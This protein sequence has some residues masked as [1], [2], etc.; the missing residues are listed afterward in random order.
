MRS[1]YLRNPLQALL[2]GDEIEG[3]ASFEGEE[4]ASTELGLRQ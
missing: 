2:T 4:Q 3:A 1:C